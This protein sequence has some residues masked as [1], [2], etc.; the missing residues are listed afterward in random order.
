MTKNS[1]EKTDLTEFVDD[2]EKLMPREKMMKMGAK[3]LE[4]W[5]LLA[6]LLRT[7]TVGLNVLELSKGLLKY[8]G[9]TLSSLVQLEAQDLQNIKEFGEQKI[10]TMMAAFELSNRVALERAKDGMLELT[11][12]K[13]AADYIMR[14][15]EN[16][17]EEHFMVL[18]L[19]NKNCL[20]NED[21][22]RVS[23]D[24]FI[25]DGDEI[26]KNDSKKIS[27]FKFLDEEI[28]SK[29]T[30]NQT[31]AMPREVFRRAVKLG[32]TSIM[33]AH[34]HPSGDPTPSGDDIR[35]TSRM[36]ECGKVL[37]IEV[38]DHIVV[39]NGNYYSLR[40]HGDM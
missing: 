12:V 4:P 25:F 1:N 37:G 19:N 34:N 39:G 17:T 20:I 16:Y 2:S 3:S 18:V 21:I 24:E 15:L 38:V 32:A 5:E 27:N 6:I 9:G 33:L 14:K 30:V 11:S 29:G 35:L 40:Q 36:V 31:I 8:G 10:T 22:A 28:I 7:G 26:L 13:S 23:E